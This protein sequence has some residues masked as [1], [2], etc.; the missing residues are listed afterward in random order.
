MRWHSFWC[1]NMYN[2]HPGTIH[3]CWY[4][5]VVIFNQLYIYIYIDIH[6]YIY[7]NI[8]IYI[9]I[10]WFI[11][12][13]LPPKKMKEIYHSSSSFR[14]SPGLVAREAS[15]IRCPCRSSKAW[16]T[17]TPAPAGSMTWIWSGWAM[18][19]LRWWMGWRETNGRNLVISW[20]YYDCNYLSI[21]Y[22]NGDF[23]GL[24]WL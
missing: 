13:T 12:A 7:I 14:D 8:N 5:L 24:Q 15:S 21:W 6:I 2:Y 22:R 1:Y 10:L 3:H 17:S 19:Q 16:R 11:S 20:D 4:N 9:Y 23:R 18:G